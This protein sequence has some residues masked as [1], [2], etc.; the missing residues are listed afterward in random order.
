[1]TKNIKGLV[2]VSSIALLAAGCGSQ[3]ASSQSSAQTPAVTQ[4]Q[5]S[6]NMANMPGMSASSTASSTRGSFGMR[7]LPPGSK[8]FFG[9][10]TSVSGSQI[11]ISGH[12]RNSSTTVSTVL[13]VTGSTQF[14]GG[15]QIALVSGTRV[16]GA[17]T[18][19]SDG[20]I[21]VT[22]MQINPTF[23]GG[24]GSGGTYNRGGPNMPPSGQ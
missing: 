17:G 4:T 22:S 3:Q 15:S 10:I 14:T 2:L 18:V 5:P 11:T 6:Q 21:T 1:M 19:N 23:T 20:S 24:R 12:S 8:A 9:A 13:N 7:N 16:A